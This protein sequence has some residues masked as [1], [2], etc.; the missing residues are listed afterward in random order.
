M[1]HF[2]FSFLRRLKYPNICFLLI[3][4]FRIYD[5]CLSFCYFCCYC[6]NQS[7]FA[8]YC[9]FSELLNYCIHAVLNVGKNSLWW[10]TYTMS[11]L[12]SFINTNPILLSLRL[13]S[14]QS[15]AYAPLSGN[16]WAGTH[17]CRPRWSVHGSS[18]VCLGSIGSRSGSALTGILEPLV[19]VPQALSLLGRERF[20]TWYLK[21]PFLGEYRRGPRDFWS[22]C[23]C[24]GY[25]LALRPT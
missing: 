25:G 15:R 4:S 24:L 7:F 10:P 17:F 6:C 22:C 13:F 11:S 9:I 14:Q 1:D 21:R 3:F 8:L 23:A 20:I 5:S 19:T 18:R 16:R 12:F 2:V